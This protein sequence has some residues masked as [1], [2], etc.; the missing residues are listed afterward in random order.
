MRF[1][2]M[3]SKPRPRQRELF[4]GRSRPCLDRFGGA[5]EHPS[6][7]GLCDDR[8]LLLG[9]PAG[10]KCRR[11]GRHS[12]RHVRAVGTRFLSYDVKLDTDCAAYCATIM[13]CRPCPNGWR[14]RRPNLT[15]WSRRILTNVRTLALEPIRDPRNGVM[16]FVGRTGVT[17]AQKMSAIDRIKIN[18]GGCSNAGLV[19]HPFSEVE[20]VV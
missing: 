19:Q 15:R 20:T 7:G 14:A 13:K 3:T 11:P 17:E 1:G 8:L 6:A 16:H 4:G 9:R 10:Q 5:C 18:A 2:S 12:G